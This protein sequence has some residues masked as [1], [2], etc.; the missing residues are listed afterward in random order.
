MSELREIARQVEHVLLTQESSRVFVRLPGL[1]QVQ[2]FCPAVSMDTNAPLGG[3][4][5]IEWVGHGGPLVQ[6]EYR[7]LVSIVSDVLGATYLSLIVIE[8]VFAL[9]LSH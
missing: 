5:V 7:S 6:P 9:F 8:R 4:G 1:P 3:G 2:Q